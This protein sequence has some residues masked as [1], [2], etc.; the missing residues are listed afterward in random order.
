M[1]DVLKFNLERWGSRDEFHKICIRVGGPRYAYVEPA[2]QF[3][4]L[5][6][7]KSPKKWL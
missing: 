5:N 6:G 1:N 4:V 2:S 3:D 7:T